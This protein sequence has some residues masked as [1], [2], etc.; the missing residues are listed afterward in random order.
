[1][2]SGASKPMWV[3]A[4]RVS[5][6]DQTAVRAV[7]QAR[8]KQTEGSQPRVDASEKANWHAGARRTGVPIAKTG[9][10]L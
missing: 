3:A 9:I 6:D 5:G 8:R 7:E 1:M 2:P 4:E 10:R